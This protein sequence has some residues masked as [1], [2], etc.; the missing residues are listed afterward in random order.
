MT[1]K[2]KLVYHHACEH[3]IY[4]L[5]DA[6][7]KPAPFPHVYVTRAFPQSYYEEMLASLPPDE[8]YK[9]RTYENRAMISVKDL[10]T[11]FWAELYDWMTSYDLIGTLI[12]L[13]NLNCRKLSLDVRLVRDNAAY[14]IKPHTDIK[15]KLLSLLFYLA[16]D[17]SSPESGTSIMVPKNRVFTSEGKV[18]YPFDDFETVTTAPFMPNTMLGFPRSDVSFHGVHATKLPIRNVLLLNLYRV[19]S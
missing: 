18:R 2:P 12:G 7:V 19:Y 14:A 3:L 16:P 15:A 17:E 4:R 9:D 1:A 5:Q 13:F 8:A 10:N 11:L 6:E